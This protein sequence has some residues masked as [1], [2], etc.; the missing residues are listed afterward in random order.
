[1]CA[2]LRSCVSWKTKTLDHWIREESSWTC[3]D[4]VH[5]GGSW[6]SRTNERKRAR[7]EE[8]KGGSCSETKG[9]T[10]WRPERRPWRTETRVAKSNNTFLWFPPGFTSR[11]SRNGVPQRLI[12][13]IESFFDG[14][15]GLKYR[16]INIKNKKAL[17][18][19]WYVLLKCNSLNTQKLSQEK[20]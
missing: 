9:N 1:M 5:A 13:Y 3:A 19:I 14:Q 18:K 10:S 11:G 2:F 12:T 4:T 8:G 15:V 17:V 20:N 7:A 16:Q 6:R